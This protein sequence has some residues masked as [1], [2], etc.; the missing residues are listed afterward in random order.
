[1]NI[2][3]IVS[4]G[5]GRRFNDALPKQYQLI[6]GRQV[7]SFVVD[8]AKK[9]RAID[10]IVIAAHK[11]YEAMLRKMYGVD[12]TE[13][14]AERNQTIR[15]GLE[16]IKK[17]YSCE[18]III[19]D[20]VRPLVTSALIEKY[21]ALLD[22]YDSIT[23]AKKITDSLGCY[24]MYEVDRE[25]YY[26]MSSPE[27]FKFDLLYTYMNAESHLTEIIQQFPRNTKVYLNFD[28]FNNVK[29]TYKDDLL[30]A[31]VLLDSRSASA[32]CGE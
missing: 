32:S 5:I 20:A 4:G 17:R 28:T 30:V 26:L 21:M 13:S 14:G 1:M 8:A 2:A 22:E 9:A 18:K 23:T 10:K 15:N 31:G 25:R 16:Y 24:D 7:I 19:L 29:I 12:W 11:K 27:A 3:L 6:S